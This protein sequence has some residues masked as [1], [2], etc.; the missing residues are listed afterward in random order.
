MSRNF[1]SIVRNAAV[2]IEQ[3]L[4]STRIPYVVI[5]GK[6]ASA[7]LA[8]INMNARNRNIVTSTTDF[9]VVVRI[10]DLDRFLNAVMAV[11]RHVVPGDLLHA[12]GSGNIMLIGVRR[13]G[14][15]E[16]LVDIHPESSLPPSV[17]LRGIRYATV[18]HLLQEFARHPPSAL[19]AMKGLKRNRR[20]HHLRRLRPA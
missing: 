8:N 10:T 6:A 16:S 15:L 7:H 14:M 20:E 3:F 5:G 1:D 12:A 9:D 2:A 4:V 11:L 18:S 19:E 17:A 13:G